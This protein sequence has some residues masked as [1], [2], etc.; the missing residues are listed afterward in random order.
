MFHI[1]SSMRMF[2]R[3]GRGFHSPW[4]EDVRIPTRGTKP[5]SGLKCSCRSTYS[6]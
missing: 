6:V 3:S 5:T 2:H 4:N 1:G